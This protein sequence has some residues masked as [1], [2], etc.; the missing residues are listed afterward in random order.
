MA[1]GNGLENR[2]GQITLREFE[3]H[4]SR[5]FYATVAQG[6]EQRPSKP[7]VGGSKPSSRAIFLK[8]LTSLV[9]NI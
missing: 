6:T 4:L 9:S 5:Q 7:W 8:E 2:R 1:Y 3:S